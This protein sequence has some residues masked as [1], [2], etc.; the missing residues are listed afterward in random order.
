M[1]AERA[2]RDRGVCRGSLWCQ[3]KPLVAN[4]KKDSTSKYLHY[5]VLVGANL[6]NYETKHSYQRGDHPLTMVHIVGASAW[7]PTTSS[8]VLFG[9]S[10]PSAGSV[11]STSEDSTSFRLVTEQ[12]H[13][14]S[15]LTTL[16]CRQ[17]GILDGHN[18]L[19][20][21]ALIANLLEQIVCLPCALCRSFCSG[22]GTIAAL[23]RPG[24][25]LC[26]SSWWK[27]AASGSLE[28]K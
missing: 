21:H 9:G 26:G 22:E 12:T 14:Y 3:E 20:Q 11:G 13:L 15:A 1:S 5:C 17:G 16:T 28:H 24:G 23:I 25:Q 7:N 4:P 27:V 6:N 8:R 18:D 19:P 2:K 10:S